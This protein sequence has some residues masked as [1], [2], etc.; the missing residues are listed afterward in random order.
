M[1]PE[2]LT[3][4]EE[5]IRA[6]GAVVGMTK[7]QALELIEMAK[8]VS[9]STSARAAI[10]M[11]E[12]EERAAVIGALLRQLAVLECSCLGKAADA[13]WHELY[14]AIC[15]VEEAKKIVGLIAGWSA[16]WHVDDARRAA[17]K[18]GR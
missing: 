10:L 2:T 11:R 8:V 17:E 16:E 18:E 3:R 4:L 6:G 12:A 9:P 14:A 5:T 7:E 13:G 1:T 15:P